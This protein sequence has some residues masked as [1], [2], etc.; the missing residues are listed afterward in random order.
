[1]KRKADKPLNSGIIST[2]TASP[3]WLRHIQDSEVIHRSEH[4]VVLYT[5]MKQSRLDQIHNIQGKGLLSS[6]DYQPL[7]LL[8]NVKKIYRDYRKRFGQANLTT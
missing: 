6:A 4:K 3:P 8:D 2:N 5:D 1:M 7:G